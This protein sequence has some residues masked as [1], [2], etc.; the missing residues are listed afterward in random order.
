LV[1]QNL[2]YGPVTITPTDARVSD[3]ERYAFLNW[4]FFAR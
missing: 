3:S 4:Y 1:E 2:T